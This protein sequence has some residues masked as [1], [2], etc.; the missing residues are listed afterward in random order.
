MRVTVEEEK[1]GPKQ[2]T[3]KDVPVGR[4]FLYAS[5]SHVGL[6]V[7][8]DHHIGPGNADGDNK[9]SLYWTKDH[10]HVAVKRVLPATAALTIT[11]DPD[12]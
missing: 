12:E 4:L 3:I 9:P 5:G 1:A 7:S 6:R 11:Y 8:A 2:L 10:S